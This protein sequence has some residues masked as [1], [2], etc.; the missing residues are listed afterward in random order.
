M[1]GSP[2]PVRSLLRDM[3]LGGLAIGTIIAFLIHL[4]TGRIEA[5]LGFAAGGLLSFINFR[6]I[7]RQTMKSCLPTQGNSHPKTRSYRHYFLRL[8]IIFLAIVFL[9]K[10]THLDPFALLFGLFLVQ[11]T[12]FLWQFPKSFL[13]LRTKERHVS[14]TKTQVVHVED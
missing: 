1:M 14:T 9:I 10:T 8:F 5:T 4:S 2:H 11:I 7:A 12:I 6:W 13:Y 3:T